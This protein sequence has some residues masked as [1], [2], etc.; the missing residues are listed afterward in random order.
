MNNN[1]IAEIIKI[2]HLLRRQVGCMNN[3]EDFHSRLGITGVRI[4]KYLAVN[5]EKDVF[6]KD[7]EDYFSLRASSVSATLKKLENKEFIIKEAVD[8]DARLKRIKLTEKAFNLHAEKVLQ[9]ENLE[10]SIEE[11]MT[12]EEINEL[13][14]LLKKLAKALD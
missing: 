2:S 7:I 9:Y 14:R 11:S 8:Y 10:K 12:L 6:Q 4:V 13:D 5:K 1:I 3:N